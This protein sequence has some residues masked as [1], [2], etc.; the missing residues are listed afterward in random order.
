MFLMPATDRVV[1]LAIDLKSEISPSRE[2]L[3]VC[4]IAFPG[5]RGAARELKGQKRER[6]NCAL[7]A[8]ATHFVYSNLRMSGMMVMGSEPV[9]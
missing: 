4:A 6:M 2:I 1:H 9:A 7:G 3:G 5:R 8:T